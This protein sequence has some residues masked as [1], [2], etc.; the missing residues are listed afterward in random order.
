MAVPNSMAAFEKSVAHDSA[1]PAG[2]GRALEALWLDARGDWA[3]AHAA[4]QSGPGGDEA[5][6]HAY[7]HR[8]EGDEGN[9]AYWYARARRAT[10]TGDLAAEWRTIG[11]QL[12]APAAKA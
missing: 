3:G 11:T 8:K 5:W 7:L 1:P 12:L 2:M 4:V 6:V 10:A 9:A